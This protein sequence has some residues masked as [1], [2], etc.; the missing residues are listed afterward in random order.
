MKKILKVMATGLV[1]IALLVACGAPKDAGTTSDYSVLLLIPG[2]LGDKSFFD[3]AN[4][5]L[6]KVKEELQ[7][8]TKVIEMGVDE[9][10]WE[11]NLIDAAEGKWDVIITGNGASDIMNDIAQE[12][13]DKKFINFDNSDNQGGN[14]Q[15]NIY[16]VSYGTNEA[17]FLAGV[18][19]ASVT[20]SDMELANADKKIGFL[21]GMDIPGINDFLVGY[22]QGALHVDPEVKV[23]TSYAGSFTDPAKG[24]ELS[25]VQY[26]SG[27]DIAFNVAGQ[28]GLGLMDAAN[29]KNKYAIGVDSDQAMLYKDSEPEKAAKILS[30][31]VKHTDV[32]VFESVKKAMNDELAFGTH[33]LM[34]SADLGVGLAKNEYYE[35]LPQDVKDKIVAAEADIASGKIVVKSGFDMTTDEITKYRNSV[36]A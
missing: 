18:L 16:S 20:S 19:A 10:K 26:D 29:D 6:D 14:I 21:G 34:G 12:Y 23:V 35:T 2:N 36:S 25:I 13:P 11:P 7:V 15:D 33:Q 30:S 32:V 3:A 27:V 4:K 17:S 5:G 31:A 9:T 28:T 22:I 8:E 24:K 1:A